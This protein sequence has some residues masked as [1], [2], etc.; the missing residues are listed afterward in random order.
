MDE[1]EPLRAG[2]IFC[3]KYKILYC[4]G[5]GG[6]GR[7]Y[8]AADLDLL[9]DVAIKILSSWQV[10]DRAIVRFQNEART[11]SRLSH[12]NIARVYD[13]GVSESGE[14]FM[15]IELVDGRS[16]GDLLEA[17]GDLSF[18]GLI[19]LFAQ[20]ADALGSAHRQG[21]VHRDVKPGN[22]IVR[23]EEDGS[24]SARV[25]DF[26]IAK[27]VREEQEEAGLTRTGAVVGSPLYMSPE[28]TRA[29]PLTARS[30]LYSFGCML[31]RA[32][33]GH[34][35]FS[36]GSALETMSM[37]REAR[38]PELF[39]SAG[40]E[41]DDDLRALVA[42]LLSKEPERRPASCELVAG[43][44]RS[45][46]RS[47]PEVESLEEEEQPFFFQLAGNKKT[48][49]LPIV[50]AVV[51]AMVLIMVPLAI[52]LSRPPE[53]RDKP[54]S[55]LPVKPALE[56][57]ID[58]GF[59]GV[60]AGATKLIYDDVIRQ[61]SD[62]DMKRAPA[63]DKIAVVRLVDQG[64]ITDRALPCLSRYPNM[65]ELYLRGSR[66][67]TLAGIEQ[68]HKLEVLDLSNTAI[69]SSSLKNLYRLD[70]L[71]CLRLHGTGVNHDDL[72][73]LAAQ[74]PALTE[75]G[76]VDCPG[77]S[78]DDLLSLSERQE[79]ARVTLDPDPYYPLSKGADEAIIAGDFE[80]ARSIAAR[81][82]AMINRRRNIDAGKKVYILRQLASS[83]QNL[84]RLDRARSL[85]E[86]SID[87]ARRANLGDMETD[88]R[89]GILGLDMQANRPDRVDREAPSTMRRLDSRP[90]F[91]RERVTWNRNVADFYLRRKDMEKARPYLETVVS[92]G[93]GLLARN[94]VERDFGTAI[95]A[96]RIGDSYRYLENP[97]EALLWTRRAEPGLSRFDPR[98]TGQVIDAV[99]AYLVAAHMEILGK[100]YDRAL[101]LNQECERLLKRYPAAAAFSKDVLRQ[102][103]DILKSFELR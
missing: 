25:I 51:I 16:L 54:L 92:Q 83:D 49:V 5:E 38:P 50:L 44:L 63:S 9:R 79:L 73:K 14:P 58:P 95:A 21:I 93:P 37:H 84:G 71:K 62:E 46:I 11:L 27:T 56:N 69:D 28:Q 47:S 53:T 91:E 78:P 1:N 98:S 34:P 17:P 64:E 31:F 76:V 40:W 20:V 59:D 42:E 67:R 68:L 90:G 82:L 81:N 22:V 18:P 57:L 70:N 89:I 87:L 102:R 52:N 29:E 55:Q 23:S 96:V 97:E 2:S 60:R 80:R 26:G 85:F 74:L 43:R 33:A 30:D 3:E 48:L 72:I 101:K 100:E 32:L 45:L 4:L 41:I 35:P 86:E 13:F 7:V 8:R 10:D 88:S 39:S 99:A 61:V 103:T 36:G 66:V 19:E 94:D 75:L 12:P 77:I 6:M 15:V 65:I 24:L